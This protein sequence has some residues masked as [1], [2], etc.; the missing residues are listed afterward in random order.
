MWLL[1][2]WKLLAGLVLIA[3]LVGSGIWLRGT[4]DKPALAAAKADASAAR[5]V[6]TAVQ[7]ARHIE[8]TVSAS[9]AAAAA[10]YEKGKEDGK[11]D[12]DG[13][14]DRLRA[15][16]RLRDQ[17]LA[18]RAGNLPAV[19]GAAGGRD[20]STPADF[21]AAH[22]EDAL[23]LAAEADDAVRQLSACQVILQAD[24]Q[25]AGQ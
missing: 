5:S 2:N 12:L 3:A 21:L 14:V 6:T 20:A 7:A 10:A 15:A 18:A 8:H 17:Q 16:V 24:R 4:I 13:A 22:G 11:Q 25:A 9:D 23:Q 1:R 19:A